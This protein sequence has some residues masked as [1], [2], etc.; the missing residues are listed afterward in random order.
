MK[1]LYAMWG[2][3]GD[4]KYFAAWVLEL[5]SGMGLNEVVATEKHATDL[6][7]EVK[8]LRAKVEHLKAALRDTSWTMKCSSWLG[9]SRY[10]ESRF[11]R[12]ARRLSLIQGVLGF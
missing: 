11:N 7:V 9:M 5:K 10:C 6:E 4:D 2:R 8:H 3:V 12:Q 1:E